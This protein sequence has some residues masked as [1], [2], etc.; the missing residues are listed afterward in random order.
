MNEEYIYI[1]LFKLFFRRA[2]TS[3][4]SRLNKSKKKWQGGNK[5]EESEK[6]A[7]SCVALGKEGSMNLEK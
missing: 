5:D 4:L 2:R 1:F 6:D 7:N 3:L